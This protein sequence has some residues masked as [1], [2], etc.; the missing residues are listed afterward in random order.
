MKILTFT[1]VDEF[2][3]YVT[4]GW[5]NQ[6]R[7]PLKGMESLRIA[8]RGLGGDFRDELIVQEVEI[9]RASDD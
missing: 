5:S 2:G 3:D 4:V 8:L 6:G 7:P 9:S 1:L